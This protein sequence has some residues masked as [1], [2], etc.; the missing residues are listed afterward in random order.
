MSIATDLRQDPAA[1]IP[2]EG[3]AEDLTHRM[4]FIQP[5]DDNLNDRT[6]MA[7]SLPHPVAPGETIALDIDF[8]STLPR[9]IA[10]TGFAEDTS[11]RPFFMVAQWFP[12]IAVFEVPGQRYVPEDAEKGEWNA[13]QFHVNSEFYADFGTYD[14][15]MRVPEGYVVGATGL[16]VSEELSNGQRTLRYRAD[17]VHDFAWTAY[18]GYLVYEDVWRHV[19]LRL[20]LLPEHE[21]QAERHLEATKIALDR[22]D[23][24]VGEYPYTT[25]TIVDGMGGANGME[26]PTLIT[27]GTVYKLPGWFRPLE[28]VIIHEFG[29]QYFYGLLASNEFEEAWLDEGMTS[30]L[31]ARIMDDAYGPGAVL[32]LPG[33]NIGDRDFQR[34]VYTKNRPSSGKLFT[35]SWE[36]RPGDYSKSSYSKPAT[37]MNT[38]EGYLGTETMLR[39]LRSYYDEWRF[40]HPTTRDLQETAESASGQ[41]LDWFFE[42]YVYGTAVL[43]YAVGNMRSVEDDSPWDSTSTWYK[44]SVLVE[45]RGDG[46]MPTELLM[47]FEDGSSQRFQWDGEDDWHEFT[48][49]SDSRLVE[50]WL[51]PDG[52]LWLE[53]N[54]L[55]NRKAS[56]IDGQLG[57]QQRRRFATAFQQ[58]AIL[59]SAL[60]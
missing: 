26:Y 17:D 13:H 37:V 16:R 10:R 2:Y 33:L 31:E 8:K 60:F 53:T 38:L 51:D 55:N 11:G 24:W 15:T 14:V 4:R 57:S 1:S 47:T 6:V 32:E 28:L 39:F 7:V 44:H 12:K 9:I 23:S 29:H 45:S 42:Q 52:K 50:A 20:L 22:F 35:R 48:H 59:L 46:Y 41:D 43:D 54:V 49:E 40:R 19:N 27:A 21:A 56:R 30:Y 34:L 18:E 36:Y 25:L 58:F 3:P 5:D